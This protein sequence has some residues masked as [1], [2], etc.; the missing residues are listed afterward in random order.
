MEYINFDPSVMTWGAW[1]NL[2]AG[3][4]GQI[5]NLRKKLLDWQIAGDS[6][7]TDGRAQELAELAITLRDAPE[8]YHTPQD[9]PLI[10]IPV[11]S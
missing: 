4:L 2:R 7:Y 5:D 6:R 1:R 10:T 9:V 11:W 8:K 3:W